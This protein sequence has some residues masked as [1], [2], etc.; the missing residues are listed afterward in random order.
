[1]EKQGR[2]DQE[3]PSHEGEIVAQADAQRCEPPSLVS[4]SC[5]ARN[6]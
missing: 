5:P 1:L 3:E 2:V 4:Y 6:S